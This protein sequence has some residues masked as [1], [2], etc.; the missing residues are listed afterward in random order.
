[1]AGVSQS[2]APLFALVGCCAVRLPARTLHRGD[3][4]LEKLYYGG[5]I[6]VRVVGS[7]ENPYKSNGFCVLMNIDALRGGVA[8]KSRASV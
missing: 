2:G 1:M 8:P 4:A 3:L 6:K 5:I 7:S